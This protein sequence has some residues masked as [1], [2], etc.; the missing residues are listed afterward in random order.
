MTDMQMHLDRLRE[1]AA[2][3]AMRAAETVDKAE[4]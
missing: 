4:P 2:E 3:C 1:D